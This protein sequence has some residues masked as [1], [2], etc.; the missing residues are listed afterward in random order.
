MCRIKDENFNLL[1][2]II[3]CKSNSI[4]TL[5]MQQRS[6]LPLCKVESKIVLQKIA[7]TIGPKTL[8]GGGGDEIFSYP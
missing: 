5:F 8:L 7:L 2:T 6:L 1:A 3:Q 4:G